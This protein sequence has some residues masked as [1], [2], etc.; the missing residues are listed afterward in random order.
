M[1]KQVINKN[2]YISDSDIQLKDLNGDILYKNSS[3]ALSGTLSDNISKYKHLKIIAKGEGGLMSN[4]IDL[5]IDSK[6]YFI[7]A[8]ASSGTLAFKHVGFIFSG[9]SFSQSSKGTKYIQGT[10]GLTSSYDTS[11]TTNVKIVEV[12]G[13]KY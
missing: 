10:S 8:Y 2:V 12:I 9:T 4:E 3:G 6:V 7:S 1:S 5:S 11:D 13:Y